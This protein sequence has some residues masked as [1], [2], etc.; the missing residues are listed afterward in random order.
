MSL[1]IRDRLP[2][3]GGTNGA[4]T[5]TLFTYDFAALNLNNVAVLFV[6]RLSLAN[7]SASVTGH[8][9]RSAVAKRFSGALS[10]PGQHD[11]LSNTGGGGLATFSYA[12]SGNQILLQATGITG[13]FVGYS[14]FVEVYVL[15]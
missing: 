9:G 6:A 12:L 1:I 14:G 2:A 3:T 7:G 5:G 8:F 13:V 11:D 4:V 15:S 10:L